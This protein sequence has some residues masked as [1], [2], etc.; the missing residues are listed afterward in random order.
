MTFHIPEEH[1][2]Y[3]TNAAFD[4]LSLGEVI[5]ESELGAGLFHPTD[6]ASVS[7]E[8][9]AGIR[10]SQRVLVGQTRVCFRDGG[11]IHGNLH[12]QIVRAFDA[13]ARSWK[14][15][16]QGKQGRIQYL[17]RLGTLIHVAMNAR[18]IDHVY[19]L[20]PKISRRVYR[21]IRNRTGQLPFKMD[22]AQPMPRFALNHDL[23][24]RQVGEFLA[25]VAPKVHDAY[26]SGNGYAAEPFVLD[27]CYQWGCEYALSL[28]AAVVRGFVPFKVINRETETADSGV[29]TVI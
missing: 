12:H 3:Y 15:K 22:S 29:V 19:S 18:L 2:D 17:S 24:Y 11:G 25:F 23:V 14:T 21:D 27:S 16:E 26:V 8:V 1:F 7:E 6:P 4:I 20:G 10:G 5:M 13:F 9:L 28:I